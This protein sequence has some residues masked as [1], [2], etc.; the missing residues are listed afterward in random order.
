MYEVYKIARTVKA[1][2]EEK[3]KL[4]YY[5]FEEEENKGIEFKS[6]TKMVLVFLRSST[7]TPNNSSKT[8]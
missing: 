2:F 8:Y 7:I 4:L 5:F 6:F 1:P 3:V